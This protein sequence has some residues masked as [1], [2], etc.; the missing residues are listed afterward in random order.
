MKKDTT[1][2]VSEKDDASEDF[3]TYNE[4]V[5]YA[6]TRVTSESNVEIWKQERVAIVEQSIIV[7][8]TK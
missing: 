1:Y 3:K 7:T 2:Y 8:R 6:E 4:A 5:D